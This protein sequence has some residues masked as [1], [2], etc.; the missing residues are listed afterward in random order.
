M[1]SK[2]FKKTMALALAGVMTLSLAA[3]GD[4][5]SGS[6]KG[7]GQSGRQES[8]GGNAGGASD[9]GTA[10]G[11]GAQAEAPQMEDTTIHIR[12]MNEFRN[13]DK[14]LAKYEEMTKDDP[15]MSKIHPEFVWVAGGDYRDK[16]QTA[17]IGQ[18]DFDL[19]FCGGWHG[20]SGYIQ[21]GNFAD[22]S[23]YFN[24]DAF[25]GLKSAFSEDFVDAMTT[26]IRQEDGSYQKGVYGINLATFYEDSR[27]FMYREDLRKKYNCDP[28][29]DEESLLN[30]V[31][32]VQENEADMIGVSLWN[33]FRL[34]SPWYSAKHDHVFSQDNVNIFGDQTWVWVGLSDDNKTVLNAV[35]PGDSAEEFAKMPA[36]YQDDFITKYIQ[37]RTKWNPYLNPNRGGTDTVEKP[38]AIAYSTLTEYESKVKTA[39]EA[40]PDEEYGFYVIEDAQRNMEPGAV[41]CDMATN[42]WL[43]VP[44]WSEKTDAVMYF[45]NWMFGSREAHDLFDLGIEGEDWEAIGEDGY[46]KLDIDENLAYSMP[47]Y[48]FTQNPAYIRVS[49][50]VSE[51][52]EIKSRFDYMYNPGTYSL[53]PLSGFVFD[54][55]KVETQIA[56]VSAL[57]NELQL[58]I[59]MYDAD[60]A[61]QK[62]EQWHKDAT[63][64]GLEEIRAELISQIQA[65]LDAK[66]AN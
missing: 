22:L 45:L 15:I 4:S 58:T 31:K 6:S 7:S 53:S 30:F 50:F 5:D 54:T 1:K 14:V 21:D 56:N 63:D 27:G 10:G 17:M 48:S 20:L 9:S 49:Q 2:I 51:N 59:S 12:V 39:L 57:S 36:G 13:L 26:Y 11:S 46:K 66:N 62:I 33:F 28:I 23:A 16:L 47:T 60:E 34:D 65:F 29:T 55:G 3:C 64:V 43:V 61:A 35:V 44:E 25:P 32:T 37:E 40:N 19:M 24:N 41:I 42:N 38:A 52:P 8:A 18:E